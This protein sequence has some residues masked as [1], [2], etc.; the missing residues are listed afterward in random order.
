MEIIHVRKGKRG[1]P[2][3]E[4]VRR[5]NIDRMTLLKVLGKR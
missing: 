1:V 5:A 3:A 2:D 4:S